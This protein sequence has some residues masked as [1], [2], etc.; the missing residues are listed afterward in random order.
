MELNPTDLAAFLGFLAL[1]LGISLYQSRKERGAEDYF[2]AGRG[3]SWWVIGLS[4]IASN[5]STEHFVGMAGQGYQ[6]G[7]GMA[8]ASYEW[9]A[10]LALLVVAFWLLPRFI[11]SGIY[12][13]PQYLEI[14]YD[15]RVR[16]LMSAIVLLFYT[17]ITMATVL[18]L[19]AKPLEV[20]FHLPQGQGIWLIGI[21][22]GAYTVYGG[23]KAVVWSD[24][25]QASALILGGILVT[26]LALREVGG[27]QAFAEQAGGRLDAVLPA[28]DP[29]YPWPAVFLGGMWIPNLY[30]W[31]LNQFITQRTLGAKSLREG[32]KGVLFG[33]SLKLIMPLIIVL[34]GI[35]AFALY[36][37]EIGADM[38]AAYP[39][40]LGHLLPT[41]LAGVMLAALFGA[42]MSTLDSLL[43]AS[44]TLFTMDFYKP[45]VLDRKRG[46]AQDR[47]AK[48]AALPPLQKAEEDRLLMR[49]GRWTTAVLVLLAC[50]WAPVVGN[51]D[52]GL[53]EFLQVYW[54]FVQPGIV[55]AFFA[56]MLWKKV[57]AGA[58][59]AAILVNPPV[60][61]M[62]L[63]ALP[64]VAFLH[65][66]G[67]AFL[68][69]LGVL[70]LWT[71]IAPR[72]A[73]ATASM[74]AASASTAQPFKGSSE[75]A[76]DT[77]PSAASEAPMWPLYAWGAAIAVGVFLLY[78]AFSG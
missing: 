7:V 60:Y 2:L 74:K 13:M 47:N 32:Q 48:A 14:R 44:A 68:A 65:H 20:L 64:E 8:I 57:P 36:G 72:R 5:I 73:P 3:L 29:K 69:S 18:L 51:F 71:L 76:A 1:V 59:I 42:V 31:G 39:T 38:D 35:A 75:P 23:L 10:A 70:I 52:G 25:V 33:A 66:M 54:G 19:G 43:N 9:I 41:G 15:H 53:Y 28:N 50:L 77:A 46:K 49:V 17:T 6:D 61:G 30:Y 37:E 58:A 16:T 21:L 62:L 26:F 56:G 12:T 4:L 67:I 78:W 22:A 27:W 55:A 45:F 11:R 34:P 40:L 24:V 63:Y